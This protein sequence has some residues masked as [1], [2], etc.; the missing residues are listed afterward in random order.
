MRNLTEVSLKNK[1]LVWYFII[2]TAIGGI[3]AY[4]KLG[5]MED[6]QF[7]IR[8]MVV[9]AAWPG[10]TAQEMQEQVTDKLEKKLQDTQGLDNIKSET[11]AGQTIIYVELSD[12]VAKERCATLGRMC[13]ISARTSSANFRRA[14]TART[15]T[16]AST[17]STARSTL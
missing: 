12:E 10:A 16:T 3:F 14:S 2:V 9:S 17:M 11:R 15:T 13:A 8:Q 1:V 7:T 6:P 5:R 4:N